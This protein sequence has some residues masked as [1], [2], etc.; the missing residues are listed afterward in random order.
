MIGCVEFTVYERYQGPVK[1]CCAFDRGLTP[2]SLFGGSGTRYPLDER[3]PG[4]HKIDD[5]NLFNVAR[6][7]GF[8]DFTRTM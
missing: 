6:V 4:L 7:L 8:L 1:I 2:I 3:K 5:I